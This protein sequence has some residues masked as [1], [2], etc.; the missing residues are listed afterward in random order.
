ML[1]FDKAIYLSLLFEFISSL[2][3][4]N[5][6]QGSVVPLFLEFINI[7]SILFYNFIEFILLLYT[8]LV[9]SLARYIE[10]IICLISFSKFTDVLPD[11]ICASV[12]RTSSTFLLFIK[13]EDFFNNVYY[14]NWIFFFMN[15]F[16]IITFLKSIND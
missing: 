16:F 12:R 15:F 4:N 1:R 5:S 9:I 3:L 7:I 2:R 10:Y 14:F 13:I 8:V 6:L 11:F